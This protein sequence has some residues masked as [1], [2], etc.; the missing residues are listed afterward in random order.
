MAIASSNITAR[1]SKRNSVVQ[2]VAEDMNEMLETLPESTSE[3]KTRI[4]S[5]KRGNF[6]LKIF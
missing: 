1:M 3:L 4:N 2:S 5:L 6:T